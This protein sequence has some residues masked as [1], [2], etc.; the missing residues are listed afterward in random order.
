MDMSTH[1]CQFFW[2]RPDFGKAQ[3]TF[4]SALVSISSAVPEFCR[5]VKQG[6][7]VILDVESVGLGV[8]DSSAF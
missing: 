4:R 1:L 2:C 6:M 8:S 3:V 5:P 7:K